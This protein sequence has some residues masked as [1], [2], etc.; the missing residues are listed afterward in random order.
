MKYCRDE[1]SPLAGESDRFEMQQQ[2]ELQRLDTEIEY[3]ES[4]IVEREQS[5]IEIEQS[6]YE[7]NE[8]FRDLGTLVNDQ[9]GLIGIS[10]TYVFDLT[11]L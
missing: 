2:Q 6:I 8:I 7:V 5:I 1:S 3:N 9:Q 10:F 11:L 4:L